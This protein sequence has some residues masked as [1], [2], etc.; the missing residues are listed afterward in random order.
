LPRALEWRPAAGL[1][2]TDG[3]LRHAEQFRERGLRAGGV[4]GLGDTSWVH[5]P[6]PSFAFTS[7]STLANIAL[8]VSNNIPR[9]LTDIDRTRPPTSLSAANVPYS[10]S[11]S[12]VIFTFSTAM[13]VLLCAQ[14]KP[15]PRGCPAS[16]PAR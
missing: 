12:T 1:P 9:G 16:P 13:I 6:T 2:L 3:L 11:I 15:Q 4:N 7:C 5:P 10:V 8:K 14:R